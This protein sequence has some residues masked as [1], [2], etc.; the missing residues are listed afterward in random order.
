MVA[1]VLL[2]VATGI[3]YLITILRVMRHVEP[4]A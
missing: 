1:A 4:P 2:T 3:D